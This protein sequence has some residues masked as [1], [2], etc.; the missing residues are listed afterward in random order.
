MNRPERVSRGKRRP[1]NLT[2]DKSLIEEAKALGLNLS[3]TFEESLRL[4]V[5]REKEKQ[6]LEENREAI[7]SYNHYVAE[8]GTIG[9]HLWRRNST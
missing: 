7:E 8:H 2:A 3:Q 6:W 4:A 5:N 9:S 1:V